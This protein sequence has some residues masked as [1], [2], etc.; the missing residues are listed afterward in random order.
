M[1][2]RQ[3]NNNF[4]SQLARGQPTL[5]GAGRG[6]VPLDAARTAQGGRSPQGVGGIRET[7]IGSRPGLGNSTAARLPAACRLRAEVP[8]GGDK[9]HVLVL[10]NHTPTGPRRWVHMKFKQARVTHQLRMEWRNQSARFPPRSTPGLRRFGEESS[11]FGQGNSVGG[12][13]AGDEQQH[14]G[15]R[16]GVEQE[17]TKGGPKS[18][19]PTLGPCWA[20][21][22]WF[23]RLCRF[24]CGAPSKQR[25]ILLKKKK[26]KQRGMPCLWCFC[27]S[28]EKCHGCFL[29]ILNF[30]MNK[31]IEYTGLKNTKPFID[32]NSD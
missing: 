2:P 10:D 9:M 15:G 19:N 14:S 3:T 25:G 24:R 11:A 13:L 1:L 31:N 23:Y 4:E 21:L 26:G 27:C 22:G 17:R 20:G 7:Q 5:R 6:E 8:G 16:D 30:Q 28:K 12:D 32:L 18:S 29:Y